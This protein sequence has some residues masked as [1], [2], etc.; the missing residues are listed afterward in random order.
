MRVGRL[1]IPKRCRV[2]A[3]GR[4]LSIG[5]AGQR[6]TSLD[7]PRGCKSHSSCVV[8]TRAG[9]FLMID[10]FPRAKQ[11]RR[12]PKNVSEKRVLNLIT[13][14]LF[15]PARAVGGLL[16]IALFA[17]GC[18][19]LVFRKP[20]TPPP[21]AFISYDS[22]EAGRQIPAP[23]GQGP[24][25]YQ[26]RGDLS[27]V[28]ISLQ[29]RQ[30]GRGRRGMFADRTQARGGNRRERRISASSPS[31]FPVRTTISERRSTRLPGT[32]SR[33]DL[34][35]A[36]PWRWRMDLADVALGTD[37]AGSIRVPAACCGSRGLEDDV[38]ARL[39]EGRL[40]DFSDLP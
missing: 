11:A 3:A 15:P 34:R 40:P 24:H 28:G 18:S 20:A 32:V 36:P 22:P 19:P 5:A 10:I 9:A 1:A 8:W 23:R 35:A 21:H 30:A 12:G 7:C 29:A 25:R 4:A 13:D 26:G 39:D 31:G 27:R 6:G 38:W 17:S 37:T 16:L 14:A 33:A 2:G